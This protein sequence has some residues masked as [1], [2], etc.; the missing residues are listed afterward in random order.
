MDVVEEII[1]LLEAKKSAEDRVVRRSSHIRWIWLSMVVIYGVLF[2]FLIP[3]ILWYTK[4]E[5]ACRA[6]EKIYL[7]VYGA[8]MP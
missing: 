8:E 7:K 6:V 3:S 2:A 1:N 4:V 5:R